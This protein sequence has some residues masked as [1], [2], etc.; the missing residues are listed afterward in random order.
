MTKKLIKNLNKDRPSFL[1]AIN[2]TDYT[3]KG[4]APVLENVQIYDCCSKI[5][6]T[7]FEANIFFTGSIEFKLKTEVTIE[8]L[9]G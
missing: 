1:S 3:L 6:K 8:K 7:I 9:V 2:V 4:D 5:L